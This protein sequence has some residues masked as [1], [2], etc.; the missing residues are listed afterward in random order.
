M[1]KNILI[2]CYLPAKICQGKTQL[3]GFALKRAPVHVSRLDPETGK[4]CLLEFK[5]SFA[6]VK[7][8]TL[9]LPVPIV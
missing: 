1:D 6:A 4:S 8:P 7:N 9:T 3:A 5:L 2:K